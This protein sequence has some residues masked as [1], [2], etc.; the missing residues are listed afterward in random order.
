MSQSKIQ[1][2]KSKMIGRIAAELGAGEIAGDARALAERVAEGL[3][4]VA[5]VGQFKRGKSTL[6]NA[7]I[8]QPLLPTGVIPVTA[9]VTVVRYGD[10]RAVVHFDDRREQSVEPAAL[11]D[12]IAEERNPRNEKQVRVVEVY[13]PSDLLSSGMCLVDTPGLG[14]VFRQNTETT[15]EFLPH[16]DAALV[17]LGADPPISGEEA[18][19]AEEIG[20]DVPHMLFVINKA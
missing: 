1:N 14:S 18:A 20:R 15:R 7:L 19:I 6:L 16:I 9:V 3:F 13:A 5:C 11:A 10:V 4:Y 17:V 2:P 12:Y 8:G